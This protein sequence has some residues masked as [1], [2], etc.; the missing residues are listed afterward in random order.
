MKSDQEILSILEEWNK[1]TSEFLTKRLSDETQ[2]RHDSEWKEIFV[3]TLDDHESVESILKKHK[4]TKEH[5]INDYEKYDYLYLACNQPLK[6]DNNTNINESLS[7]FY[8]NL[9]PLYKNHVRSASQSMFFDNVIVHFRPKV[10]LCLAYPLY[11]KATIDTIES[12]PKNVILT[13]LKSNL[14]G[15][16]EEIV[17]TYI[18]DYSTTVDYTATNIDSSY[19]ED[20][21]NIISPQ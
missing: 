18:A 1:S 20:I 6:I 7:E 4:E 12:F 17:G 8:A 2:T 9:I 14:L 15:I 21:N 13:P 11:F 19:S 5:N 3:F 10:P 16:S